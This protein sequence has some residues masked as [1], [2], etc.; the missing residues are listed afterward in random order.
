MTDSSSPGQRT[1]NHQNGKGHPSTHCRRRCVGPNQNGVH[2]EKHQIC[3]T[4]NRLQILIMLYK[5]KF[6]YDSK[7]TVSANTTGENYTGTPATPQVKIILAPLIS[8]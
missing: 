8:F 1:E 2:L 4:D 6:L 5:E 7:L 3:Y